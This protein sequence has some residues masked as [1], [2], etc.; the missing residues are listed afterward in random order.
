M[1]PLWIVVTLAFSFLAVVLIAVAC[2]HQNT[3]SEAW[4]CEKC[5]SYYDKDLTRAEAEAIH[6]ESKCSGTLC[7]VRGTLILERDEEPGFPVLV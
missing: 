6:R 2:S 4:W 7:Y 5:Q 3:P 1:D